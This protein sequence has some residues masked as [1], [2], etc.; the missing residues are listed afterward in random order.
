[1]QRKKIRKYFLFFRYLHLKI[2][3]E[4]VSIKKKILLIGS[5]WVNK[6]S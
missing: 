6:Q 4:I 5:Q 3:L 2:L 1:M